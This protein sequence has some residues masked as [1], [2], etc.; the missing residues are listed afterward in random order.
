V[1]DCF[2]QLEAAT[3]ELRLVVAKNFE[4]AALKDNAADVERFFKVIIN[5][6]WYSIKLAVYK[7]I[8]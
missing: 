2:T 7:T 5:F 4:Q 8:L 6:I 1:A 3:K